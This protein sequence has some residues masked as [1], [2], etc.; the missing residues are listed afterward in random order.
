MREPILRLPHVHKMEVDEWNRVKLTKYIRDDFKCFALQ[1]T[2]RTC[3]ADK[4]SHWGGAGEGGRGEGMR[5]GRGGGGGGG[6]MDM[7]EW[8]GGTLGYRGNVISLLSDECVV[9]PLKMK[10]AHSPLEV[11]CGCQLKDVRFRARGRTR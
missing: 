9:V 1:C 4:G 8:L 3:S 10:E 2:R 5:E 6:D 7:L 11:S